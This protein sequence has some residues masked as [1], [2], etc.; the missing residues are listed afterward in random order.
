M[1]S[2]FETRKNSKTGKEEKVEVIEFSVEDWENKVLPDDCIAGRFPRV[3]ENCKYLGETYLSEKEYEKIIYWKEYW[4]NV[5]GA[6]GTMAMF[7]SNDYARSNNKMRLLQ[8]TIS[9]YESLLFEEKLPLTH[10]VKNQNP[11]IENHPSYSIEDIILTR[12]LYDRLI[13]QGAGGY[14]VKRDSKDYQMHVNTEAVAKFY[15]WLKEIKKRLQSQWRSKHILSPDIND[16]FEEN[17]KNIKQVKKKLPKQTEV[18][19][20]NA[21]KKFSEYLLHAEKIKLADALKENFNTRKGKTYHLMLKALAEKKIFSFVNGERAAVYESMKIFFN[22]EIGSR[23]S[24]FSFKYEPHKHETDYKATL[25]KV[26][27][28]LSALK[29]Q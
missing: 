6:L 18:E 20:K 19:T 12:K 10:K 22:K 27:S 11:P 7:F 2:Y 23:Q 13:V 8:T 16:L 9:S 28:I 15:D 25:V 26:D 29:K 4:K 14:Q 5:D 17:G 1:N 24:I 21:P 3:D